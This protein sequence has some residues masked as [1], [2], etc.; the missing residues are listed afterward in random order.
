M[1]NRVCLDCGLSMIGVRCNRLYCDTCGL[2]R[3]K[4][5]NAAA[6][7]RWLDANPGITKIY[8]YRAR[9]KNRYNLTSEQHSEMLAEQGGLC[10][11]DDCGKPAIRIDHDHD[12][13][14]VR[15]LLCHGCN[16]RL[17]GLED[18]SWRERALRYLAR[19]EGVTSNGIGQTRSG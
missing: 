1:A 2:A 19:G 18:V 14:V 9:L 11:I 5:S 7:G 3:K 6:K 16:I 17:S 4:A 8:S 13:G 10:A 12:T 15:G